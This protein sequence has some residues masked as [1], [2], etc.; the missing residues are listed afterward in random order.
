MQHRFQLK[1]SILCLFLAATLYACNSSD[2]GPSP[3]PIEDPE[4]E[5]KTAVTI[6][7]SNFEQRLLS[8]GVDTDG[9]LNGQ[10]WLEDALEVTVL[11]LF[12]S[13]DEAKITDLTGIEVF[14]NLE[15]LSVA[16]NAL[17]TISLSENTAL[18]RLTLNANQLTTIDLSANTELV[19]LSISW[20][21][22]TEID[23]SA[24]TKLQT[25][26]L[27]ANQLQS[28]D[29]SNNTELVDLDVIV[30]ELSSIE[31]LN[32]A[33][34]L[35]ELNL[36]W[37]DF[38]ELTLNL[39]ALTGLNVEQNLLKTLNIDG[40][41]SLE[42]LLATV[43]KIEIL[44]T[45]HNTALIHLKVSYNQI[46]SLNLSS[47]TNLEKVWASGNKL[48]DLDVSALSA[49]YDLR[50]VRN[51]HLTCIKINEGQQIPTVQKENHQNLTAG[52]CN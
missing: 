49:L 28:L 50:I 38:E 4:P 8:Q 20:N 12:S 22:L 40:C 17:Q 33:K 37:N 2:D 35:K 31:G 41:P 11:E 7:D 21:D 9:E 15:M 42:Y 45:E 3:L 46:T 44:N 36:A 27:V 16:N 47:N 26:E 48:T 25:L 18:E 32:Q 1:T 5:P 13:D 23:L 10:I 43:N 14:K 52:G 6:P 19:A 29:I 30:N 34:K 24:N 51:E 39:P